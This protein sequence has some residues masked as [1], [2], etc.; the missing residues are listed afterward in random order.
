MRRTLVIGALT[1]L[2]MIGVTAPNLLLCGL[3]LALVCGVT[4]RILVRQH[5]GLEVLTLLR[6]DREFE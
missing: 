1:V 5:A 2:A 6:A 4:L 3:L